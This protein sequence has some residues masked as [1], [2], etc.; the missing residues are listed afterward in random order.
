MQG[1]RIV[2]FTLVGWNKRKSFQISIKYTKRLNHTVE[3]NNPHI[4]SP[5]TARDTQKPY[6]MTYPRENLDSL[7]RAF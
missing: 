5:Q 1:S 7:E 4:I 6:K 2:H 3:V